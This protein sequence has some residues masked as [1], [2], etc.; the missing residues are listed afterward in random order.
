MTFRGLAFGLTVLGLIWAFTLPEAQAALAVTPEGTP[1]FVVLESLTADGVRWYD[2]E[3]WFRRFPGSTE[4]DGTG[5]RVVYRE[6]SSLLTLLATPPYALQGTRPLEGAIPTRVTDGRLTVAERFLVERSADFLGRRV[7]VEPVHGTGTLRV[8][9]DPGHG[10][11]D[12]GSTAPGAPPEK[13][14]VLLLAQELAAQLRKKGFDARLTRGDDRALA[15]FERAALANR[16][17]A[18][19]FLSLH[20]SG[21]GRAQ[22]RGYEIFLSQP[23]TG[24]VDGRLWSSGQAAFA[25]ES[26]RWAEAVHTEVGRALATFDRG[27]RET[28]SPLLEAVAGPACLLEAGNLSWP[29]DSETF[30]KPQPRAALAKALAD[31]AEAFFRAPR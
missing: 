29:E 25:G 21:A 6:G 20:A 23:S 17:N 18:D 10:G 26:R 5:T 9:V 3:S 7:E 22:A 1:S 2:A 16:W 11:G 14:A 13:T 27:V 24:P 15:L 8:L 31:A 4:A 28:P 19:L 30:T 12:R